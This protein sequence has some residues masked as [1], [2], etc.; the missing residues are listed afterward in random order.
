MV[1]FDKEI[2]VS[3]LQCPV[4]LIHA[5]KALAG[6]TAGQVLHVIATDPA[7][8]TLFPATFKHEAGELVDARVEGD[9]YYYL[10]RKT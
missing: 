10:V 3:G 2:D 4:P 8:T 1:N 9:K 6:M 7:T 5:E